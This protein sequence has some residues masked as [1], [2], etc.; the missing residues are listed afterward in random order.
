MKEPPAS[1][2][3]P[4]GSLREPFKCQAT[5]EKV[6]PYSEAKQCDTGIKPITLDPQSK[7]QVVQY[8]IIYLQLLHA[9][10]YHSLNLLISMGESLKL[11]KG[12][13]LKPF[14]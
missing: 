12:S 10:Q 8:L 4:T 13:K 2:C 1:H 7:W 3:Y 11:H 9:E 6:P 14:L 5:N